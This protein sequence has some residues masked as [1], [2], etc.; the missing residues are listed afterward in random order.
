MSDTPYFFA[1]MKVDQFKAFL[2]GNG[3]QVLAPTNPWEVVRFK[4]ANGIGVVYKNSTGRVRFTGLSGNAY[5]AFRSGQSYPAPEK[6]RRKR[7]DV[8]TK[9]LIERDGCDCFY[10]GKPLDPKDM[11]KEHM[12]SVAHGGPNHICNLVIA[13]CDCNREAG[14]LSVAEKV[15]LRDAKRGLTTTVAI[16]AKQ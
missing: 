11:T 9:A 2:S 1:H 6:Q 5:K 3:H 14:H 7:I 13:C 15:R 12:L 8:E 16:K 4:N 10:C